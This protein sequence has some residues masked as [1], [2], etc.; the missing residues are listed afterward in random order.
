MSVGIAELSV[1]A[2]LFSDTCNVDIGITYFGTG[3]CHYIE[4][5]TE[6]TFVE[7]SLIIKN[8]RTPFFCC[9]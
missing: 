7:L 8:I 5:R 9:C 3:V 1:L 4:I 6:N 2:G